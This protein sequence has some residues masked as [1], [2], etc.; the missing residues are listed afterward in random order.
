VRPGIVDRPALVDALMA[1]SHAPVV[2]VSAPAGHGKTTLLALWRERDERPFAWASLEAADND[3]VALV[4]GMLAALDPVLAPDATIGDELRVAAPPL[5]EVVLPSLVDV[6]VERAQP[7][8]LVLDDVDLVTDRRCQTA[9]GYVAELL[10]VGASSRSRRARIRRYRWPVGG[11]MAACWRCAAYA[12]EIGTRPCTTH[13]APTR[14]PS[15]RGCAPTS[16]TSPRTA[17]S[18]TC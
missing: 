8:V 5:E 18:P 13:S 6:C 17:S 16:Q 2:L 11:R 1:N 7:F 9:I 4:E 12:R 14:S 3:P 10:P 15:C